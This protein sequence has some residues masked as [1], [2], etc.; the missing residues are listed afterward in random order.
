MGSSAAGAATRSCADTLERMF[1]QSFDRVF[2]FCLSRTRSVTRAEDVVSET[3]ADAARTSERDPEAPL[4]EEWLI[5]VA[6]RR[7]IDMWRRDERERRRVTR[8]TSLR[9]SFEAGQPAN[10]HDERDHV[11]LAAL[12]ELPERQR[13]ALVL[14]H[15][16]GY[17]VERVADTLDV[18]YRA[19]ES[20]LSRARR[21]FSE[22]YR[23]EMRP[24]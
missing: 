16:D 12:D 9:E 14:R 15:V 1:A 7:I 3:F 22:L 18:S 17:S 11:V 8:L 10:S 5:A 23:A 2:R 21:N 4:G 19:A 6:R 20:L 24:S 13:V